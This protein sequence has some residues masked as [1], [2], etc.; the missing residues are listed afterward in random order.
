MNEIFSRQLIWNYFI[1]LNR[2]TELQKFI[3]LVVD[4]NIK[5]RVGLSRNFETYDI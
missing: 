3:V 2:T 5:A 1:N 4:V